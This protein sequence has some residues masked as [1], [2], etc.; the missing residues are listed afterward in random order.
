VGNLVFDIALPTREIVSHSVE[1]RDEVEKKSGTVIN[2]DPL[3]D[4]AYAHI[5]AVIY[6]ASDWVNHPEKP[7]IEFTVIHNERAN[8]KLPHGWLQIGDEYW[9]EGNELH[10]ARH[11]RLRIEDPDAIVWRVVVIG[12]S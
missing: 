8:V 1:H 11:R 3:L 7:G 2:T 4:A 12:C 6:S 9:R 10:S 5:S